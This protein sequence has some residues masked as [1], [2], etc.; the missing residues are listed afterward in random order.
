[1]SEIVVFGAGGRAGRAVTAESR[2]RGHRVTAVVRAPE[3]HTGI[4]AEGVRV[5]RG[6]IRDP[7]SVAAVSRGQAAAVHAVSPFT[8]PEQGFAGL[9]PE[10]YVKAADALL[11]GLADAQVPRLVVVGLF[12][13]LRTGDGGSVM[14]DPALFPPEIRP[15]A[16]AHEAGLRRLGAAETAVDWLVLTPPALLEADAPRTGRYR[17]GGETVPEAGA[18]HLSYAD[19]AVALLDEIDTPQHHRTRVSVFD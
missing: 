3:R 4:E 6:D 9:D 10:F 8:G 15:F 16:R 12:A 11:Q 2:A 1:M 19:L 14:D 5:L 7:Q 18:A 17:I 13:N